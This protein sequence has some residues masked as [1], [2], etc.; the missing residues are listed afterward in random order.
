MPWKVVQSE[1]VDKKAVLLW[2][3]RFAVMQTVA[4]SSVVVLVLLYC[5]SVLLIYDSS[6]S[7]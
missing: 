1:M 6:I 2:D 3:L 4:H 7:S 5:V